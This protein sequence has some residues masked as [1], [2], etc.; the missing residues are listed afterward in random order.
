MK[1]YNFSIVYKDGEVV[2]GYYIG[3]R[4]HYIYKVVSKL[5]PKVFIN[6]SIVADGP[7]ISLDDAK[8]IIA[9]SERNGEVVRFGKDGVTLIC[10]PTTAEALWPHRRQGADEWFDESSVSARQGGTA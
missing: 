3:D 2:T 10:S 9:T 5:K 6:F 8:S 1:K 4:F 7:E